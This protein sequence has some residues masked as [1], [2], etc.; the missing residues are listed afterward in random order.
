MA[1]SCGPLTAANAPGTSRRDTAP[2]I[3][4]YPVKAIIQTT[5]SVQTAKA[6]VLMLIGC[7]LLTANDAL[8]KSLVTSLPVT[9]ILGLR[10][11]FA[12]LVVLLLAPA[13]GGFAKLRAKRVRDVAICSGLLVLNILSFHSACPIC[14]WQTQ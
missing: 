7:G 11:V 3:I 9:Q 1:V 8:M 14:H 4:E 10:G 12:L 13:V 6:I 2:S 5:R